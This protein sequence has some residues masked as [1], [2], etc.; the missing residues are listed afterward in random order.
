MIE[1]GE[2]QWKQK[3]EQKAIENTC[4]RQTRGRDIEKE[5]KRTKKREE[6]RDRDRMRKRK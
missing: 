1:R 5:D 4:E 3:R 6:K 2:R